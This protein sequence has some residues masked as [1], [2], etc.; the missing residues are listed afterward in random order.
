MNCI[1]QGLFLVFCRIRKKNQIFYKT[2]KITKVVQI[3]YV[4]INLYI[5]AVAA[6]RVVQC[7]NDRAWGLAQHYLDR[8]DVAISSNLRN[9]RSFRRMSMSICLPCVGLTCVSRRGPRYPFHSHKQEVRHNKQSL[10]ENIRYSRKKDIEINSSE[11]DQLAKKIEIWLKIR[12]DHPRIC[13]QRN[14]K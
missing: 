6:V 8:N 14:V 2:T 10:A 9:T 5:A 1:I 13:D 12:M 4:K 11:N 7:R 3:K